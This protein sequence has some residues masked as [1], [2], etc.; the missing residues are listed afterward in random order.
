MQGAWCNARGVVQGAEVQKASRRARATGRPRAAR[1][2]R[3]Q[4]YTAGPS[5]RA[6]KCGVH[7]RGHSRLQAARAGA[8]PEHRDTRQG[9]RMRAHS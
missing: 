7:A 9:A 5:R 6:R 3:E 1:L 8:I 2:Q 4:D